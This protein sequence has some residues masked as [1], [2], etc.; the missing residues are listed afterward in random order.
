MG[1][2]EGEG[3]LA[4]R[5]EVEVVVV[6]T[7]LSCWLVEVASLLLLAV[8]YSGVVGVVGEG[9]VIPMNRTDGEC[10]STVAGGLDGLL[11][12]SSVASGME[13]SDSSESG[14]CPKS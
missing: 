2:G 8:L 11:M 14:C 1:L 4:V 9:S 12:A 5:V 3:A 6:V 13:S 7:I 10:V